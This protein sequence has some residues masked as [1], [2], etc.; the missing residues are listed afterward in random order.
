MRHIE[1]SKVPDVICEPKGLKASLCRPNEVVNNPYEKERQYITFRNMAPT[2]F[3]GHQKVS[4][5]RNYGNEHA[6]AEYNRYGL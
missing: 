6:C 2:A 5:T 1:I 4:S 3:H